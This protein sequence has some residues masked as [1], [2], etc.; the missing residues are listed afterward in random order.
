MK[1]NKS[2]S[3]LLSVTLLSAILLSVTLLTSVACPSNPP[4]GQKIQKL[5][6]WAAYLKPLII[7]IWVADY[8]LSQHIDLFVGSG[9]RNFACFSQA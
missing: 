6:S 7:I 9:W 8:G 4:K 2:E 3:A 1:P 5:S